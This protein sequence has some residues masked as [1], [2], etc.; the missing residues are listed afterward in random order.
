MNINKDYAQTKRNLTKSKGRVIEYIAVHY[1]GGTGTAEENCKYF[2][3]NDLQASAD[4]FI[5]RDGSVF[6]FNGDL[7]NYYSWHCGDGKGKNGIT[8]ANSIG[9]ECVSNGEEF[10]REQKD[11]LRQLVKKLQG[12]YAIPAKNIV[13]HYDASGKECPAPYCGSMTKN[14]KWDELHQ[15]IVGVWK[16]NDKGWWF[17]YSDGTYA[18]NKWVY[19]KGEWYYA[20]SSGYICKSEWE[21]INGKWY[22]FDSAGAMLTGWYKDKSGK[23]YHLDETTGAM[24]IGWHKMY[25][26]FDGSGAAVV[27]R[28]IEIHDAMEYFDEN[29]IWKG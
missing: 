12:D 27:D 25:M 6:Q 26:Y 28:G 20:K 24:T 10:A 1:T 9:I 7:G 14:A 29:G 4:F 15:Y 17:D 8:N 22:R 16:K 5:D 2:S 23:L 3:S 11:S 19:D 18:A 13:R 21:K